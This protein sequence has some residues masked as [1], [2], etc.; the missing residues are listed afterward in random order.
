MLY[1]VILFVLLVTPCL[2]VAVQPCMGWIR[3]KKKKKSIPFTND[4]LVEIILKGAYF[5]IK[6]FKC[7]WFKSYMAI[8]GGRNL[9]RQ[10]FRKS[11][12]LHAVKTKW[13]SGSPSEKQGFQTKFSV[14]LCFRCTLLWFLQLLQLMHIE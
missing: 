6:W 8:T 12:W 5:T 14:Q 3:L 4:M 1:P 2:V 10:I 7:C 13:T 11:R 9:I